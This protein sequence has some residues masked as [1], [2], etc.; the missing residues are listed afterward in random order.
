[1]EQTP[2]VP[3]DTGVPSVR[4]KSYR[5]RPPIF[6]GCLLPQHDL[7]YPDLGE[8]IVLVGKRGAV[9]QRVIRRPSDMVTFEQ[10][11]EEVG[12]ADIWGTVSLAEQTASTNTLRQEHAQYD[13]EAVR[14]PKAA[15][16]KNRQ[17]DRQDIR[18]KN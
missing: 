15:K 4:N 13:L 8:S 18:P 6:C 12:R 16:Q 14:M 10:G 5:S 3:G 9:L 17:T 2:Q 7:T 1:M 11:P